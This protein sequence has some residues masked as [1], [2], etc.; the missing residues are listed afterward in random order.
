MKKGINIWSFAPGKTLSDCLKLSK[1]AGFDGIELELAENGPLSLASLDKDILSVK[2]EAD[3]IGIEIA[4]LASGL[5]WTYG[6]TNAKADIR[7]KAEDIVK[8]QLETAEILGVDAVL[9]VPGA[10]GVDFIPDAEVTDYEVAYH[11]ALESL[12]KLSA[13]AEA[14]KVA[15]AV[16]NVWNKFLLSPLEMKRF[17]DEVGSDY[18]GSY[19]DIGNT[20]LNGYPE[21]WIRSLNRRIKKV[22]FKDY[23]RNTAGLTGFVDLLAGDVD[24]PAVVKELGQIGY[25][26]Y[27]IAEMIPPYRH[28]PDQIIYNTSKSMDIILGRSEANA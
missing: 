7:G 17:L 9:V 16:E 6:L 15:I 27:C 25:A 26:N 10:V 23:R 14:H 19:L 4:G 5:G 12:V 24:Y 13:L 18:V 20:V 22:H 28:H 21:H 8:K 1:Q 3:D 2:R 11:N